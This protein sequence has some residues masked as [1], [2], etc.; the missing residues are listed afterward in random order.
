MYIYMYTLEE[1]VGPSG[2]VCMY[3]CMYVCLE[4]AEWARLVP[5]AR[6]AGVS[7]WPTAAPR[8]DLLLKETKR[9][10]MSTI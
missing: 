9:P 7:C 10:T 3:V 8:Q 6:G 5:A 2:Y 4:G 1:V